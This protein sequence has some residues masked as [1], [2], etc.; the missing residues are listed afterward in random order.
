[1]SSTFRISLKT[2][3]ERSSD[4]RRTL[5]TKSLDLNRKIYLSFV[6]PSLSVTVH[7][8]WVNKRPNLCM[9]PKFG[10]NS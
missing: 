10:T 5:Q 1:M 8:S 4:I 6:F 9:L 3:T 2:N 7:H